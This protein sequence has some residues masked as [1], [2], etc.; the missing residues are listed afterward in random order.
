MTQIEKMARR[1]AALDFGETRRSRDGWGEYVGR[2]RGGASVGPAVDVLAD[3][4]RDGLCL[5]WGVDSEAW[6]RESGAWFRTY[7]RAYCAAIEALLR[8]EETP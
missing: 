8:A 6:D 4:G 2:V 5:S 7:N 1:D 3:C